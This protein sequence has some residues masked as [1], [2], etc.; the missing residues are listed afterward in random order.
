MGETV[1]AFTSVGHQLVIANTMGTHKFQMVEVVQLWVHLCVFCFKMKFCVWLLIPFWLHGS[2]QSHMNNFIHVHITLGNIQTFERGTNLQFCT[3]VPVHMHTHIFTAMC[4]KSTCE[5]KQLCSWK[6]YF[7]KN[8]WRHT[9]L[10]STFLFKT[11]MTGPPTKKL[12]IFWVRTQIDNF[13]KVLKFWPIAAELK[14]EKKVQELQFTEQN[15]V[16]ISVKKKLWRVKTDH[17]FCVWLCWFSR[18]TK[19]ER[20]CEHSTAGEFLKHCIDWSDVAK[21]WT[22]WIQVLIPQRT[23][24]HHIHTCSHTHVHHF[25]ESKEQAD[26]CTIFSNMSAPVSQNFAIGSQQTI[27]QESHGERNSSE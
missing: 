27:S 14:K 2:L 12:E 16:H 23:T 21:K 9:C 17:K 24:F 7:W 6:P 25:L 5:L 20:Q 10:F 13:L 1:N 8:S 15:V 18:V 3:C 26:M 11:F 22:S 19:N 4:C